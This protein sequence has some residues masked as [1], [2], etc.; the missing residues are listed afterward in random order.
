MTDEPQVTD[1]PTEPTE[2]LGEPEGPEVPTTPDETPPPPDPEL[3]AEPEQPA[4][5]TPEQLAKADR[6]FEGA[7]RRY[8]QAVETYQ[9]ET[10]QEFFR[11]GVDLPGMPGFIFD[12][13]QVPLS[14]EQT[15]AARMLA[16]MEVNPPLE[17]D[18]LSAQCSTC[19]GWGNVKTG[20][21]V[22]GEEI[23]KCD[24]CQGHG[25][26]GDRLN[27]ILTSGN[28]RG[29]LAV[30]QYEA[31]PTGEVPRD[32]WGTPLGHPGYGQAPDRWPLEWHNIPGAP[33]AMNATNLHAVGA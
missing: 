28:K 20:S 12:P 19:R 11:T 4:V 8:V 13:R 10:G 15:T 2:P 14:E 5:P 26:V 30:T 32:Q 25:F 1:T 29:G 27:R 18:P 9:E 6:K 3:P 17:D 23:A 31:A 21:L 7:V 33:A 22:Q 24:T 16:G